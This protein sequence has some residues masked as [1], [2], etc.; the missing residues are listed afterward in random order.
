M[1]DAQQCFNVE[2]GRE[3]AAEDDRGGCLRKGVGRGGGGC[4][5]FGGMPAISF[6]AHLPSF[7][8][9]HIL[10][11]RHGC[12]AVSV[13]NLSVIVVVNFFH[14]MPFLFLFPCVLSGCLSWVSSLLFSFML[15]DN[16]CSIFV[17]L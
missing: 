5:G 6:A 17:Y 2:E 16:Y 15:I 3:R 8:I 9:P 13:G 7:N 11:H 1:G 10:V 4:V 12:D 14:V